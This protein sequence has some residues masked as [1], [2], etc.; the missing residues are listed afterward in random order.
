MFYFPC[1]L[2]VTNV[3]GK[4]LQDCEQKAVKKWFLLTIIQ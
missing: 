2:E 3:V 1:E 4:Y